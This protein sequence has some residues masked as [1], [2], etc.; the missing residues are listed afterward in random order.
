VINGD[1]QPDLPPLPRNARYLSH[2]NNCYDWGTI[3][4]VLRTQNVDISWFHYFVF[5]NSSVRGPNVPV[6]FNGHWTSA[7]TE[8]ISD[9]VKLVGATI[10]CQGIAAAPLPNG[11]AVMHQHP[12]VQSY[13]VATDRKGLDLIIAD[14]HV[15][16]CHATLLDTIINAEL[17]LSR[18]MLDAG[19]NI[20]SLMARYQGVDWRSKSI[21]DCNLGQNPTAGDYILDGVGVDATEVMFVKVK[22]AMLEQNW[23]AAV[24]A[25]KFMR[26][27]EG[28]D[29]GL[30]SWCTAHCAQ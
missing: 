4:W 23:R 14:G 8:R 12:H 26:M 24:H 2:A 15:L 19:Y 18:V 6:F 27:E 7:L 11:T 3:G 30:Q 29:D 25:K 20:D 22:R 28:G 17:G 16:E 5:L 21:W 10:N 9:T 1:D 13:L